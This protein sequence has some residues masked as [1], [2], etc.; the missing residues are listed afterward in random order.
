MREGRLG[1]MVCGNNRKCGQGERKTGTGVLL[2][3]KG[4]G[5]GTEFGREEG[6][7]RILS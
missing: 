2:Q 5:W 1:G 6:L 7:G 3:H 4:Q